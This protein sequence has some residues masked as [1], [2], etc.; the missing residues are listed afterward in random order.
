MI[1]YKIETT[2]TTKD[3]TPAI[4]LETISGIYVESPGNGFFKHPT[5]QSPQALKTHLN[6]M[7]KD[8]FKISKSVQTVKTA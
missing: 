8:G 5:I 3:Y 7:K 4:F 6:Q 1:I 2:E